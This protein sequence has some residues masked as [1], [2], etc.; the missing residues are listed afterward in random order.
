M[1]RISAVLLGAAASCIAGGLAACRAP[2]PAAAHAD[3]GTP[4]EC[5]ARLRYI[6][7]HPMAGKEVGGFVNASSE[8]FKGAG[9]I[10][11]PPDDPN[12]DALAAIREMIDY[13][14]AGSV[15]VNTPEEH[16]SVIA[17]TSDLMHIASAML[18]VDYPGNMTKAHTA[19]A[20]RDCTRIANLDARLWTELLAGNMSDI[21]PWLDR[22]IDGLAQIR[23]ALNS[24][25]KESLHSLLELA[26]VNKK[27][28]LEL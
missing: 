19:G 21:I 13:I 28:M 11:T 20:F 23:T 4:A 9:F 10:I 14:G 3:Q 1:A 7:I 2:L 8:I 24:G 18:C 15:V 22:Y 25:D 27:K 5:P 12:P 16:D 17:Y 26:A 6:G